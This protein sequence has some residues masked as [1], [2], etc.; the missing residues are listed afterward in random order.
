MP[1]SLLTKLEAEKERVDSVFQRH[2][3][4]EDL[5]R[6]HRLTQLA[7]ECRS[8]AEFLKQGFG[9]GWTAGDLQ[10]FKIRNCL[11]EFLTTFYHCMRSNSA[12]K[13][14]QIETAWKRFNRKRIEKL[15]GCL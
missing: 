4:N 1:A 3:L 7:G 8:E 10:T 12:H 6:I 2:L 5:K 13:E 11:D 9:I 14:E 15:V